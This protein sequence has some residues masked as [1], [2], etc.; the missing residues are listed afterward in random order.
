MED[1][2]TTGRVWVRVNCWKC[3]T[4]PLPL[5][6]VALEKEFETGGMCRARCY[7]RT[8]TITVVSAEKR[9]QLKAAGIASQLPPLP[10]PPAPPIG[11]R[12]LRKFQRALNST[13]LLAAVAAEQLGN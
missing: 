5:G 10:A 7:C 8:E 6:R 13:D 12:D 11:K 2:P 4:V 3:G 1:T 9:D